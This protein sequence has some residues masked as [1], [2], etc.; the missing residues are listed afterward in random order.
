MTVEEFKKLTEYKNHA[1]PK[2]LCQK[3]INKLQKRYRADWRFEEKMNILCPGE[4]KAKEKGEEAEKFKRPSG[5]T[6]KECDD[7]GDDHEDGN[8]D[9][10]GEQKENLNLKDEN[11]NGVDRERI[12]L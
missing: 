9:F 6:N 4:K 11:V 1:T 3:V 7:E 12:P 10:H 5:I 8:D 2:K